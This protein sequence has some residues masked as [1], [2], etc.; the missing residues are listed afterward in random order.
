MAILAP[1]LFE[2]EA[3][4]DAVLVAPLTDVTE[5]MSKVFVSV[6]LMP[7]VILILTVQLLFAANEPPEYCAEPAP[8]TSLQAPPQVPTE[9]FGGFATV[10][11]VGKVSRKPI[12]FKAYA[13]GLV[14]FTVMVAAD[15]PLTLTGKIPFTMFI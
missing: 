6:S 2:S 3:D 10:I 11:P 15:P 9:T 7:E 14:I 4:A 1:G 13:V 5:P 12:P 8:G